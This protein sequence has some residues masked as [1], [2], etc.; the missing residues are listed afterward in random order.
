MMKIWWADDAFPAA[1]CHGYRDGDGH[2]AYR[3]PLNSAEAFNVDITRWK[4]FKTWSWPWNELIGIFHIMLL[5]NIWRKKYI[6]WC[7]FQM[8]PRCF[9]L[10]CCERVVV[11]MAVRRFPPPISF[12]S[13]IDLCQ[14]SKQ[15]LITVN[16]LGIIFHIMLLLKKSPNRSVSRYSSNSSLIGPWHSMPPTDWLTERQVPHCANE[17]CRPI[18][19]LDGRFHPAPRS[20]HSCP[21]WPLR[22]SWFFRRR[23]LMDWRH[24]MT[25]YFPNELNWI[26]L[27]NW[28]N[29]SDDGSGDW[30]ELI[31]FAVC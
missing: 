18:H 1:R 3:R 14:Y 30:I 28:I 6:Y 4:C 5:Y 22:N 25:S 27:R 29:S 17:H 23:V 19:P 26:A 12:Q 21:D 9:M 31:S 10:T 16:E 2:H 15:I 8:K 13:H 7:I 20:I 11:A 24:E